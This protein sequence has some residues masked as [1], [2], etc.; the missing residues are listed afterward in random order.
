[1]AFWKKSNEKSKE[2]ED[3]K[4]K[5]ENKNLPP[6]PPPEVTPPQVSQPVRLNKQIQEAPKSFA[7]L[8]V[9]ID[10][11]EDVIKK[12][13]E[14][15][16]YLKT[17]TRLISFSNELDGIRSDL[18]TR[19]KNTTAEFTN[20]LISLDEIFVEPGKVK[21]PQEPESRVGEEIYELEEEL[22]HLRSELAQIK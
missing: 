1:M 3:I 9:K 12:L 4:N 10:K 5:I 15:K 19:I 14:L 17:L 16:T 22:K 21:F 7:P 8:F 18:I 20:T 11:Y 2:I 6:P 13:S